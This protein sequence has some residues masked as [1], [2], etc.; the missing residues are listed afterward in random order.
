MRVPLSKEDRKR[1]KAQRRAGLSGKALLDDFQD[2]IADIVAGA[3]GHLSKGRTEPAGG[4]PGGPRLSAARRGRPRLSHQGA[5]PLPSLASLQILAWTAPLRATARAKSLVRTWR[6]RA[7]GAP[8]AVAMLTCPRASRCM[9]AALAWT[10]CAHGRL[11]SRALAWALTMTHPMN[12]AAE[13]AGASAR[14]GRPA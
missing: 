14:G 4:H 6:R 2:D 3:G 1:L 10:R 7:G 12:M 11:P 8:R 5:L 13:A 9:S